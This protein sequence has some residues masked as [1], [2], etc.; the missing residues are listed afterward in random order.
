MFIELILPDRKNLIVGCLYRH[1][2]GMSIRDF[3]CNHLEPLLV[4]ISKEKKECALMGDFNAD[5]L[6]SSDSNAIGDLYNTFSSHFFTP[7]IL[8]P[9]R[10]RAKTLIDNIFFNSLEYFS[11]SGNLLYEL[12]DHLIQFLILE[13]FS[14]ERTLPEINL[15]KR[16]YSNFT[17]REFEDSVIK[18]VNWD[19]VCRLD[20]GDPSFS[21]KF[22]FFIYTFFPH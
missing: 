22:F 16:N 20:L 5:L 15:F 11:N 8:Q 6:K 3:T 21:V 2:S 14:K 9:T 7:F 13:G 17:D 10:L 1:P 18:G 12:S 19:D 4:K